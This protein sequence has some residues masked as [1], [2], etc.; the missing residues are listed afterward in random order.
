MLPPIEKTDIP[1]A[2]RR[3]LAYAA[4]FEPSGWY[5]ATP[6]PETT[7][8]TSTNPYA[9][10][11]AARPIPTPATATPDGRSQIAPRRSDQSPNSG[12]IT[13]DETVEARTMT[14][15][16]GYVRL[17]RSTR[18]GRRAGSAPF[19]KSTARGPLE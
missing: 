4:N 5:A 12:C 13:D 2:R 14:P 15:A 9:G 11:A 1:L 19:E 6:M 7:T 8:Q 17:K 3:P 18:N 16:S 10:E